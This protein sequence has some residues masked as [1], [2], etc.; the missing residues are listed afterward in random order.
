MKSFLL[1][2]ILGLAAFPVGMYV[3]F[4]NGNPPV[5][6]ADNP[7]PME[8]DIVRIPL[9]T[10]LETEVQQ[11]PPIEPNAANLGAGTL[12]YKRDCA[13]CHGVE[14]HPSQIAEHMYPPAPQLWGRH[15]NGAVGVSMD[16]PGET[17]WKI[18]NGIR[19]TGMPAF[20]K[21]LTNTQ[22]WQ[23][24][25]LLSRAGRPMPSGAAHVLRVRG[26][27]PDLQKTAAASKSR[28]DS[29]RAGHTEVKD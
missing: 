20:G 12:I 14:G 10:R 28:P 21:L 4:R 3:Y 25:L 13:I 15:R 5:A 17:Y 9:E 11:V 27:L 18:T 8:R 16:P 22:I 23:V 2:I 26:A 24:T 6:V 1:G 7:Y 19:L 29:A